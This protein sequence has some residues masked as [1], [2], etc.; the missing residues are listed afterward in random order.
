MYGATVGGPVIH[1][2]TFFYLAYQGF[3]QHSPANS[4]YRVPTAA[5]LTGDFSD[6]PQ[7]ISI[8]RARR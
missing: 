6:W 5:N 8:R 1:N 2:K 7:Q 3:L 4:L